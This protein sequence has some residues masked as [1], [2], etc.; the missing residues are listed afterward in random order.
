MLNKC[1]TSPPALQI[2][3]TPRNKWHA[4]ADEG[5][6]SAMKKFKNLHCRESVHPTS[7][8][9][10]G[11]GYSIGVLASPSRRGRAAPHVLWRAVG[12]IARHSARRGAPSV[13]DPP[14]L[15]ATARA[16]R[17]H[18]GRAGSTASPHPALWTG[19]M[20]HCVVRMCERAECMW[21][22]AA[23][24]PHRPALDTGDI[25]CVSRRGVVLVA[26]T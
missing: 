24:P 23:S 14:P 7:K 4:L 26:C 18:A 16:S 15:A 11:P 12:S 22:E 25:V 8:D 6:K 20:V 21:G 13:S 17:V 9:D 1:A 5:K 19:D 3:V 10:H 2:H